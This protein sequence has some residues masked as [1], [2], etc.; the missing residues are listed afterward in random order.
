M[1]EVP[2]QF[3]RPESVEDAAE[4]VAKMGKK[5]GLLW[6]GARVE[7]PEAWARDTMIDLSGLKL[8]GIQVG[9]EGAAIGAMTSIQSLVESGD[10]RAAY[11]GLLHTAAR[12]LAHY[13]LR[14]MATVGGTLA[15]PQGS[16]EL[17]LSLLALDA[18]VVVLR[19][20]EDVVPLSDWLMDAEDDRPGLVTEVRIPPAP[21]AGGGWGLEWL[22]RSPMDQ[23]LAAACVGLEMVAGKVHSGR[24]AVAGAGWPAGRISSAEAVLD[25]RSAEDWNEEGLFDAVI[26]AVAPETTI[27]VSAEYQRQAIARLAVRAAGAAFEKAGN[28]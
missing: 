27:E 24:I 7:Q 25:G 5:A 13:G 16:P 20:Q 3:L 12:R 6:V 17:I 18:Q 10:I 28:S 23:A 15:S 4:L 8:T 11:G 1:K 19:G 26:S 9:R 2:G 21:D 14:N 22:G